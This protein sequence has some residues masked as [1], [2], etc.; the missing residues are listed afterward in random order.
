M[1]TTASVGVKPAQLDERRVARVIYAA[2]C[3]RN[4]TLSNCMLA[5]RA[6]EKSYKSLCHISPVNIIKNNLSYAAFNTG[7]VVR[8]V[9]VTTTKRLTTSSGGL[10]AGLAWVEARWQMIPVPV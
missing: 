8:S 5:A 1:T 6:V 7:F 4:V 9:K 2:L 10:V 3:H